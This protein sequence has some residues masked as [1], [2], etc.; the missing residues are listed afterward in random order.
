MQNLLKK[1]VSSQNEVRYRPILNGSFF[2]IVFENQL[3]KFWFLQDS[4]KCYTINESDVRAVWW[5][6]DFQRLRCEL[7]SKIL[8]FDPVL[9]LPQQSRN[10]LRK[11]SFAPS[12]TRIQHIVLDSRILRWNGKELLTKNP[13]LS[14]C[15]DFVLK[16][17]D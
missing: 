13:T 2:P 5:E 10:E 3:E 6:N 14:K 17:R 7:S 12:E 4:T 9:F 15:Q 11:A 1:R 8:W 16:T